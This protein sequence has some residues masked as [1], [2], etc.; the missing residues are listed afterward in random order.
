[1]RMLI[2]NFPRVETLIIGRAAYGGK[3]EYIFLHVKMLIFVSLIVYIKPFLRTGKIL[4]PVPCVG[5]AQELLLT[6]NM[7]MNRIK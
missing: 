3:A 6:I 7:H 2:W 1:M 4:L 5:L